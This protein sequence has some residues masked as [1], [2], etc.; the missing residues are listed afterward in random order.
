M[1]QKKNEFKFSYKHKSN[2]TDGVVLVSLSL[3]LN[4]IHTLF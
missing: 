1:F 4:I 3:T 2:V